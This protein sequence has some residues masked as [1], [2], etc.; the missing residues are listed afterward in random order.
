MLI[1]L[2]FSV[3]E[4]MGVVWSSNGFD[5]VT[6]RGLAGCA[7]VGCSGGGGGGGGCTKRGA[8]ARHRLKALQGIPTGKSAIPRFI[9]FIHPLRA[10]LSSGGLWRAKYCFCSMPSG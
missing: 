1:A 6:K 5:R 4:K 8:C 2:E 9:Q 7:L 3:A 10:R